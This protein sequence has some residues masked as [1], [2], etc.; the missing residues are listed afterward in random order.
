MV[1]SVGNRVE[2]L[3]LPGPLRAMLDGLTQAA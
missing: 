1:A 3:P 2:A